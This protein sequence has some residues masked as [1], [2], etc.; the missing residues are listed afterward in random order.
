MLNKIK[1]ITIPAAVI[2]LAIPISIFM[3]LNKKKNNLEDRKIL[4]RFGFLYADY[5]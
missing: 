2:L 3:Y 5:R 4:L 1:I